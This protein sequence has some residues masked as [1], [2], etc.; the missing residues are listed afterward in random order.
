[1]KTT[2]L[3]AD[4]IERIHRTSVAILETVGIKVPHEEMLK[5]F[6]EYS[7]PVP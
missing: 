3:E 5:L 1:M 4:S 2:V 7:C 6:G